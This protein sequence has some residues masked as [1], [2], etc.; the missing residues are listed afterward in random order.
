MHV[1]GISFLL[2]I[3][4]SFLI[5]LLHKR[6]ISTHLIISNIKTTE[7]HMLVEKN[8]LAYLFVVER[9]L[10]L[11]RI[12]VF[13]GLT[14]GILH[15][16]LY[17]VKTYRC[18]WFFIVIGLY[19]VYDMVI[20]YLLHCYKKKVSLRISKQ[21]KMQEEE[22]KQLMKQM[23]ESVGDRL[24]SLKHKDLKEENAG[25]RSELRNKEKELKEERI[26]RRREEEKRMKYQLLVEKLD[27]FV[28]CEDCVMGSTGRGGEARTYEGGDH[29]DKEIA[30][31][32]SESVRRKE[33]K[34]TSKSIFSAMSIINQPHCSNSCLMKYLS[35]YNTEKKK[36]LLD[37]SKSPLAR[38]FK[39][40]KL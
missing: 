16:Y 35:Y 1:A 9:S 5:H 14:A 15:L 19:L 22:L 38:I 11:G 36:L 6:F 4:F 24:V 37:A 25:L 23:G 12:V 40:I 33:E 30:S 28:W 2:G 20:M 10:L 8:K 31:T 32:Q 18:R 29:K 21:E 34:L 3:L 17:Q 27:V 39:R 7:K 26:K 13:G